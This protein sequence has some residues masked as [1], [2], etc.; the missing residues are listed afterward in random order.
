VRDLDRLLDGAAGAG[1][2]VIVEPGPYIGAGANAAGL[3]DWLLARNG[4]AGSIALRYRRESRQWLRNVDGIIARH[5]LTAGT[6]TVVLYD[7]AGD[8]AAGSRPAFE[9]AVRGDGV[10][11]PFASRIYTLAYED[12]NWGWT[13]DPLR[14]YVPHDAVGHGASTTASAGAAASLGVW[15]THADDA[16]ARPVFEDQA[17]PPL[18]SAVPL[19]LDEGVRTRPRAS[20]SAKPQFLGVDD[21]GFHNGAVWYRGHFTASG[22]ER[23]FSF[24]GMSGRG[25]ACAVW[26]NGAYLGSATAA[27]DGTIATTLP[28]L[29]GALRRGSRAVLSVLFENMGHN[30]SLD[31]DLG[32]AE[33]RGMLRAALA[34]PASAID[35]HLLG[36][37]EYNPDPV[38]G[39]LAAGGLAGEI[40]GWQDPSFVDRAWP[41]TTLPARSARAGVTWYRGRVA[42]L[43]A[44]GATEAFALRI[45]DARPTRYRAL[46][47]VN[48]W[49]IGHYVGGAGAQRVFPIPR[50]LLRGRALDTIAIAVWSLDA[51]SGLGRVSI[52]TVDAFT[53]AHAAL[54]DIPEV[55][56]SG[57]VA[58]LQL[59]VAAGRGGAPQFWYRGER[60]A[61][62]V[63]VR[64]GDTLEIALHNVLPRAGYTANAVNL[65]FHGLEVSPVQPGDEVLMTLAKPGQTLHYVVRVPPT[66]QPGLYWY[67]SHSHGETYWQITSGLS[68]ALI[69]DG[70]QL[71]DGELA[72]LR[73]RTLIVRDVQDAPDIMTIPWYARK[74]TLARAAG[75][76]APATFAAHIDPD[77]NT[78]SSDPCLPEVGLHLTVNGRIAPAIRI[79]SGERQL[80]RVVNAAAGRVLDLAIDGED[81][82]IVALDGYALNAYPG[83]PAIAWVGHVVVPPAGRAEFV[84]TGQAGPT[85]LRSRC[86]DSGSAGDRDP[87]AVL[88]TLQGV[89]EASNAASTEPSDATPPPARSV[90]DAPGAAVA[91]RTIRLSEDA[92]GFYINGRAFSMDAPPAVVARSGTLEE[93]TILNETDEVHAFHLHQVHFVVESVDGVRAS[94]RAWR[95]TVIVPVRHGAARPGSVKVLV[96]F[97][98]PI[99]R[100]TFVF[101][102]HMLDHEDGGMMAKI[103][104]I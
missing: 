57:G 53:A 89:D 20:A 43:P 27:R 42:S 83:S 39:P 8:A 19:D 77:D 21:Y 47:Y 23:A 78:A 60:V 22:R 24:S 98:N 64:P 36:N 96:D 11:V 33:P 59:D 74:M 52:A 66:Q 14:A 13:G 31:R 101:H 18:S 7:T 4:R 30:E 75:A 56:S 90:A 93:W 16:E 17:W 84:A 86:Y 91:H 81:I 34:G 9:R 79:A 10:T 40:A 70:L 5:Q 104:V 58:R 25:G 94:P 62:T 85:T 67:H 2:Y 92:H 37:G 12:V 99:V 63:R 88:A 48:G 46:L 73:E 26:L 103:R 69:V 35:W 65:H 97:R 45:D 15:R 29:P 41:A 72:A 100:G 102:C 80:F 38:R 82:G 76:A 28:I 44:L 71:H 54:A 95:D 3:P 6:G 87:E 1:L 49:L 61:P 51:H 50:G 68:G 55:Q 32:R